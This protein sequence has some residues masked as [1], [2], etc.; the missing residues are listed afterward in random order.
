MA[1]T[2]SFQHSLAGGRAVDAQVRLTYH[3]GWYWRQCG[4]IYNPFVSEAKAFG[5]GR[6][7]T[8]GGEAVWYGASCETGAWA[9]L[10]RH[11]SIDTEFVTRYLSFVHIEGVWVLDFTDPKTRQEFGNCS[12]D[13]LC[14][15]D[16]AFC[17]SVAMAA[18]SE[19][20]VDGFLAPSAA[21]AA[22]SILV[23]RRGV[24]YDGAGRLTERN[25]KVGPPS[26]LLDLV[27][28]QVRRFA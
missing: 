10:E 23:L 9:E 27:K 12:L 14:S 20:D 28:S 2:V 18:F 3:S 26:P 1:P 25:R 16:Y 7:H 5:D 17:Q 21:L 15:D 24:L 22:H 6:Y 13:D 19:E 11:S 8:A 4:P